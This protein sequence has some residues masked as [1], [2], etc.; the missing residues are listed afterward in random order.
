MYHSQNGLQRPVLR[1]AL[2]SERHAE[3]K[4]AALWHQPPY[5]RTRAALALNESLSLFVEHDLG[6]N[7]MSTDSPACDDVEGFV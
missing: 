1:L 3:P 6:V 7:Y 5:E 2:Y 4:S